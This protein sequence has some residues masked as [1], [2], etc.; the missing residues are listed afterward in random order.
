MATIPF[1]DTEQ[2]CD[3]TKGARRRWTRWPVWE[4][5]PQ[6]SSRSA[7]MKAAT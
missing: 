7:V 5:I 2:N 6:T 3:K 1:K 4:L